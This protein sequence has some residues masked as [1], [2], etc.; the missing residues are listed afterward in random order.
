MQLIRIRTDDE[1]TL[2]KDIWDQILAREHND[3]PFIEYAWFY[4]WW[5]IIGRKKRVELY[6]VKEEENIIAFFPFTVRMQWGVRIYAF[7]GENIANYSGIIALEKWLLSASTFVFDELIKKHRHVIFSFHGLLESSQSSKVIE[8]YFVERQMRPSIFRVITPYLAFPEIDFLSYFNNRRKMHGV[9]RR[10][11][12]LKNLGTLRSKTP[13]HNEL[14][15]MF[16]LFDRRWAKKMD[17]SSFTKGKKREFFEHLTLL[18]DD[19]LKVDIEALVFEDQWIAF[20][21]GFS[22]RGRYVSYVLGHEPNFN[23]FGVGRILHHYLIKRSFNEGYSKFDMSI[24]YEPYKFDWRSG[25]DFTRRMIISSDTKRAKLVKSRFAFKERLKETLKSSHQVV[26]WKR[27][28]L[29]QLR[30]LVKY[31][32]GKDWLE[33]GQRFVEKFIRFKQVDV[34]ELPPTDS[35]TPLRPVGLLFEEMSIQEAMHL[36]QEAIISLFYQGYTIYKDSFAETTK[37]AFAL[38]TDNWRIDALQIVESLPKQTYF[39]TYDVYKNI[40][41]ITDFFQKIKPAHTLWVTASVWQWR[42]RKRL[43]QLGY[44]RISRIKHFKCGRY[45]RKQVEKYTE[46]GGDVHSVH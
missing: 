24:G 33:Y 32:K 43:Q 4:N 35:V 14:W 26:E 25:I 12:K 45:E 15:Q 20:T 29:G 3:N 17:T 36:N 18:H 44:K 11:R 8:Q 21:Y 30:Y 38:H 1:L 46:S 39:L 23:S 13:N 42:K 22:C 27:N 2:Y 31:G 16:R 40:D 6:A 9:D 37:P 28:T 41:I 5:K 19:A 34:F 10:E 7:A